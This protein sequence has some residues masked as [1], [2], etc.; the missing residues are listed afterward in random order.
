M[1]SIRTRLVLYF[2]LIIIITVVALETLLVNIIK[3]NYYKNLENSLVNQ[4]KVSSDIYLRFFSDSTLYENVQNDVDVFW[5]QTPAQVEIIDLSGNVLMDSIP[6]IPDVSKMDDV[7]EAI[8]GRIGKWIGMVDYDEGEVMA[9]SCPL[10]SD[11]KNVGVLRFIVS[12]RDVNRD[13]GRIT[14]IFIL[15]GIAVILVCGLLSILFAN[16]IVNP[17]KRITCTAEKMALGD[18]K[19]RCEK[20]NDDEIGKLSDTL[21]HMA[22]EIIKKEQLKNEF[23]SSISHELRTPLTSI[24]GWAVTLKNGNFEDRDV[25]LDGLD[26]IE[27]ESD[28]LTLMVEELL[29][30]SK[31]LSGKETIK[32]ERIDVTKIAEYVRTQLIPRAARDDISFSVSYQD[33]LP[34]IITDGNRL[35]QIFINILDNAFKFTPRGGSVTFDIRLEG[36]YILFCI[37]DTGSGI[38]QYELPRVKEKFYKGKNSKWGNGIGLS[39]CDELIKYM[40]GSLEISSEIKKGTEVCVRLPAHGGE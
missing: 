13:I 34:F 35:K 12:L 26:I 10:K 28:R 39:I 36:D 27:K 33:G 15:I 19:G 7:K 14:I 3:Q 37:K 4:I 9:V 32:K 17:L 21:N 23:I 24:K 2:M 20:K 11:D 31:F 22:E 29:D 1:K 18:Y 5:R 25:M 16:S 6:V 8:E 38:S 30:F 40:G